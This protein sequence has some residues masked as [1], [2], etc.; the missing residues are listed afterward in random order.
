MNKDKKRHVNCPTCGQEAL[1]SEEN[2]WR[3]F[4]SERCRLIDLSDWATESHRIPGEEEHPI[5][6]SEE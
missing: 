2:P 1:W 3:P 4:C 5:P 6:S